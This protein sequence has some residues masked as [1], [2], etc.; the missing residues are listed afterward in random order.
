MDNIKSA[1]LSLI[2]R[3]SSSQRFLVHGNYREW[4]FLGPE[5]VSL[6]VSYN[7]QCPFLRGSCS[8]QFYYNSSAEKDEWIN[9]VV[10]YS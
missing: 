9:Q 1:V 4:Y 8:K 7:I 3:L 2:E 5:A 10:L 6:V